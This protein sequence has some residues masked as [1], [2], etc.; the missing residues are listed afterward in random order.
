[1]YGTLG[2]IHTLLRHNDPANRN[3]GIELLYAYAVD[4]DRYP[5]FKRL[6]E[7]RLSGRPYSGDFKRWLRIR[8]RLG[9][10]FS[11]RLYDSVVIKAG[12]GF[13]SPFFLKIKRGGI[14]E[15]TAVDTLHSY[16]TTGFLQERM[17]FHRRKSWEVQKRH[18]RIM[19]KYIK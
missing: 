5:M 16:I 4:R 18:H 13:N 11:N 12:F 19:K 14:Y 9:K 15:G 8:K 10:E 2:K 17:N 3:L 1:M 6:Y 7:A